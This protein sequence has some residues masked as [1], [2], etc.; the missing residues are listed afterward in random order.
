[1]AIQ[2]AIDALEAQLMTIVSDAV[3]INERTVAPLGQQ[4][5]VSVYWSGFSPTI[6]GPMVQ[7]V[8]VSI[9][10]PMNQPYPTVGQS[11]Y[12]LQAATELVEWLR[13]NDPGNYLVYWAGGISDV[14]V[15]SDDRTISV[16]MTIPLCTQ[17]PVR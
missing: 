5:S 2:D 11:D 3:V 17:Y 6:R 9:T 12:V 7:L 10:V 14:E 15:F 1:M 16:L 13:D 4:R 8:T